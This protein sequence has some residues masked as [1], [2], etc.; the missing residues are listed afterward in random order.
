[1][2]LIKPNNSIPNLF[3][4]IPESTHK[5]EYERVMDKWEKSGEKIQPSLMRRCAVDYQKWLEYCEDDRTKG[6]MLADNVPCTLFFALNEQKEI[7]GAIEINHRDTALGHIHFGVVPWHRGK[8]YGT[9]ML[10][11]ALKEFKKMGMS[12]VHICPSGKD[13]VACIHTVLKNG[14]YLIE[15]FDY[16][17]IIKQRYEIDLG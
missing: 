14:G 13:N 15:E 16:D 1:M 5:A 17:G 3:L 6:S 9:A 7:V 4:E 10:A 2:S 11:S 12:K 8:G